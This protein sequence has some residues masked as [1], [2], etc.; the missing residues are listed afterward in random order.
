MREV[1]GVVAS[2][3]KTRAVVLTGLGDVIIEC[4]DWRIADN[5]GLKVGDH[6]SALG[7]GKYPEPENGRIIFYIDES[8]SVWVN[9]AHLPIRPEGS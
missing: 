9:R 1:N 8:T 4:D 7:M 3:D 6:L 5:G 2:Y